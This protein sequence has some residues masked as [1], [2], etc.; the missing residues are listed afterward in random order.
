MGGGSEIAY[1]ASC[2]YVEV[3]GAVRRKSESDEVRA[4][5]PELGEIIQFMEGNGRPE[6]P[7]LRRLAEI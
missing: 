2:L 4:T 3:M 6:F 7:R 1:M 5:K